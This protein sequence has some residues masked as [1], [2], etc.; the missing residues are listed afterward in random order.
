MRIS[1]VALI[2]AML[3]SLTAASRAAE[4]DSAEFDFRYSGADIFDGQNFQN[5]WSV[6]GDANVG[7]LLEGASIELNERG[8]IV[9]KQTPDNRNFWIQQDSEESPWEDG[10]D[11]GGLSFSLEIRAHLIGTEPEGDPLNNGFTIWAADGFQR[12]IGVVQEDSMQSFG[13]P[14]EILDERAND[15]GFHTYRLNYDADEDLYFMYRDG[16][17]VGDGFFAQAPTGNNRLIVGDCCTD[18]NDLT[19]FVFEELE[20]EYVR[21]DVDGAFDPVPIDDTLA[22]DFNANGVRDVEDLDLLAAGMMTNDASFDLDNDGDAD[23]DDRSLWVNELANTYLGDSNFDGEFNSA[24]FVFVFTTAKYE[25]GESATWA[26]GD[27]NGDGLFSSTDF[28]A[29][30]AGGG[31]EI[32][33]RA[34]APQAV[35]EP[36]GFILVLT[37]IVFTWRCSGCAD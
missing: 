28:V 24:D 3:V 22:G 23:F 29:G 32:G 17:L 1:R 33:P 5:D 25:S 26:E 20:I 35:P 34:A 37:A 21:Y 11:G 2:V 36:S 4:L 12:G 8:N 13:R 10:V 31:Y 6:G 9:L 19:P 15:D 27:W 30:F 18:A 14:G 16:E 7:E